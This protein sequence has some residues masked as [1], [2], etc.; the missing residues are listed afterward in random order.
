MSGPATGVPRDLAA[1]FDVVDGVVRLGDTTFD[2]MRPRSA[3]DLIS[4]DDFARDERLPYWA[5]VWPSSIALGERLLQEHGAGCSLLELGCGVGVVAL[6]AARAGFDVTVSDYY[7]DA[8]AFARANLARAGHDVVARHLDWRALPDDLPT[9]DVVVASDVLYE[10][11][12]AEL[13]AAVLDRA[14]APRGIAL[15]AD[16]GRLAAPAFVEAAQARG[17][18]VDGSYVRPVP[19]GEI[20]QR[21]RIYTLQRR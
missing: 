12:Y 3:E 20:V 13:V 14:L 1:R 10:R 6:A 17:F 7:D 5:D 19:I 9:Y 16:P 18:R 11:P 15:V 4:E 21:I 2:V 8:L